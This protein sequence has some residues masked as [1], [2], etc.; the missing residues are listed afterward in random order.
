M[1]EYAQRF[2][3]LF[4]TIRDLEG[5]YAET[6]TEIQ[7]PAKSHE[8]EQALEHVFGDYEILDVIARGGMGVVYKARQLSLKRIV[9]L[10]MILSGIHASEQDVQ[11]FRRE[12]K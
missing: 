8:V 9:A 12:S 5:V 1:R 11:R 4:S 10:K 2:P 3:S 7:Q 6:L